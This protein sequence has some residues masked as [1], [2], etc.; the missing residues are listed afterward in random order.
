MWD[1]KDLDKQNN[2][3]V[4]L[5]PVTREE[6]R[7]NTARQRDFLH[8]AKKR[9]RRLGALRLAAATAR[10]YNLDPGTLNIVLRKRPDK[11]NGSILKTVGGYCA[12]WC[13][14]VD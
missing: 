12:A 13:D 14:E 7:I 6:N 1:H 11:Q 5:H 2:H 8:L 3:I 10:A 4:N 9:P